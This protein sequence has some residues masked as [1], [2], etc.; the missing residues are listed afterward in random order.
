MPICPVC[1][2]RPLPSPRARSCSGQCR[3]HAWEQRAAAA[4][5]HALALPRMVTPP[6][7][8]AQLPLGEDRLFALWQYL[9][10]THA[11]SR[12]VGYRLGTI[13]GQSQILHWFP[14]SLFMAYPMFRLEPFELAA[15]PVEGVY[16]VQYVDAFCRP[17]GDPTHTIEVTHATR[18]LRFCDGD[19][20]LKV[21][22]R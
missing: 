3:Y 20:S 19:R 8:E 6:E 5:R 11:P 9:H 16:V 14:S 13:S 17:I 2:K 7:L 21:R 12:S 22:V 18:H 1:K 15:V 4:A 10:S